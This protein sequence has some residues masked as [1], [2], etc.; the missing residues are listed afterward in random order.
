MRGSEKVVIKSKLGTIDYQTGKVNLRGFLPI[1]T[2]TLP[3]I[4][5]GVVPDQRFD[6]IPKRNQVL[7]VDTNS[8]TA[9]TVNFLDSATGNY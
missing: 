5:F 2:G 6:I 3:Y 1:G 9:I 7:Q 4:V 8:Q